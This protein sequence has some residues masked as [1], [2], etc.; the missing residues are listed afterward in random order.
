MQCYSNQTMET[1]ANREKPHQQLAPLVISRL[2]KLSTASLGPQGLNTEISS[3]SPF[4]PFLNCNIS[5]LIAKRNYH[6]YIKDGARE[7]ADC[8]PQFHT[9]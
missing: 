5:R 6:H 1:S 3:F 8:K 9:G 2:G 7:L 4:P